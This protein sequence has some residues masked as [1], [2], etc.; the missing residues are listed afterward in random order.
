MGNRRALK[1]AW[2]DAAHQDQHRGK[3]RGRITSSLLATTILQTRPNGARNRYEAPSAASATPTDR[4]GGL[5]RANTGKGG[6]PRW[7]HFA[8]TIFQFPVSLSLH[9]G[10]GA[11]RSSGFSVSG[12]S[13]C[14]W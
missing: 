8:R 12:R 10:R 4:K 7:V 13:A 9:S 11:Y 3:Q 14:A 1:P 2:D 6:R 5:R